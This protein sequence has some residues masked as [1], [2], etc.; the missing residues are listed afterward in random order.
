M[1]CWELKML[2]AGKGTIRAWRNLEHAIQHL[3]NI[4]IY[5]N[6]VGIYIEGKSFDASKCKLAICLL[7]HCFFHVLTAC[8]CACSNKKRLCVGTIC[9]IQEIHES[10]PCKTY[11]FSSKFHLLRVNLFFIPDNKMHV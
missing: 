4:S 9:R 7:L 11:I 10:S 1:E 2:K 3:E 8:I 6:I 5:S